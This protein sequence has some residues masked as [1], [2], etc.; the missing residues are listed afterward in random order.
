MGLL[1][2]KDALFDLLDPLLLWHPELPCVNRRELLDEMVPGIYDI[3]IA[4]FF[5]ANIIGAVQPAGAIF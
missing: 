1:A 2:H 3:E 5:Y 4:L